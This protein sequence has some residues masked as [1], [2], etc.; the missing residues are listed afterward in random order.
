MENKGFFNKEIGNFTFKSPEIP[1]ISEIPEIAQN[2]IKDP[3]FYDLGKERI[4]SLKKAISEI[5]ILIKE[6]EKLSKDT[7]NEGEKLK[8][9]INNFILENENANIALNSVST[10]E[11]LRE[12]NELRSKK[13]TISE[14]QLKEKIDCWKD[15]AVLKKELREL[16]IE[17]SEKENRII[18]LNKILES[19]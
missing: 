15:V 9:E 8:T 4:E 18:A 6:R 3:L 14:S 7:F 17:L 16:E 19:N 11:L 2:S 5:K 1:K 12:K 13:I 10:N